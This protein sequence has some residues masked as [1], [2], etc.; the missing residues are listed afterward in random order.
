[1]GELVRIKKEVKGEEIFSILWKLF[2]KKGPAVV[3]ENVK[4]QSMPIVANIFGTLDRWA[5]A[6]GFPRGKTPREYRTMFFEKLE[7]KE[8][9][10]A[11]K[12]VSNGPC[13][14]VILKGDEARFSRIPVFRWHPKDSGPY[15]TLPASITRDDKFGTNVG[16][17]RMMIHD[18]K[19]SGI[20]CSMFQHQGIYLNRAMKKGK[21]KLDCA[22]ALGAHPNIYVGGVTT[23][24]IQDDELA[25]VGALQ[26]KPV[27]VVKAETSDLEVPASAEIILEGEIS[28]TERKVEAPFAEYGGYHEEAMVLPVFK[29]KCITMRKDAMYQITTADREGEILRGIPHQARFYQ[30]TRTRVTGFVDCWTPESG[31][32]YTAVVSIKKYYPGWGQQAIYQVLGMPASGAMINVIIIVDDDIDPADPERWIW[33]I[34]TRVDPYND[35]VITK[36][37]A[38]YPLNPGVGGKLDVYL[39]TGSSEFL[40]GSKMGIDAT[41]KMG[42]IERPTRGDVSP[43]KPP[44][45]IMEDLEK[46]WQALGL[47]HI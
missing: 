44:K 35:V 40:M 2:D 38:V 16:I 3:F 37:Q 27:E 19:T 23:M 15:I 24:D 7:K 9:W 26:N 6:C 33:A 41:S 29:L 43:V 11:P 17:Y 36:P 14:E 46:R 32:G 47:G 31:H 30:T 18:D 5:M 34:S 8:L 28:T 45:D 4:G 39:P 21:D 22:I 12:L 10:S 13:K 42:G 1:M 20:M 25:L